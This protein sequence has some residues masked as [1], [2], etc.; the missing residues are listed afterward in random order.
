[1]SKIL[2]VPKLEETNLGVYIMKSKHRKTNITL[3]DDEKNIAFRMV[4]FVFVSSSNY[5]Y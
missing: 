2:Y 3:E 4:Y 1:M 5:S